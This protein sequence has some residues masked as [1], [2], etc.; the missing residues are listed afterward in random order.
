MTSCDMMIWP[1][2]IRLTSRQVRWECTVGKSVRQH[3]IPLSVLYKY[4]GTG[5]G[6]GTR[7][8]P[9]VCCAL[10]CQL[11]RPCRSFHFQLAAIRYEFLA[12]DTASWPV[13]LPV[14][15]DLRGGSVLCDTRW[16]FIKVPFGLAH[17]HVDNIILHCLQNGNSILYWR[18]P[19][20][21]RTWLEASCSFTPTKP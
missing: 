12:K 14:F 2:A 15:L 5:T 11:W 7:R 10:A 19:L 20:C 21:P 6:T 8:E 17:T 3:P 4:K 18:F 1:Y 9:C 16:I 13:K